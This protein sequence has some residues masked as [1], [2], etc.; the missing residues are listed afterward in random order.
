MLFFTP[1]GTSG[2]G[3][4]RDKEIDVSGLN[5]AALIAQLRELKSGRVHHFVTGGGSAKT[6]VTMDELHDDLSNFPF[7]NKQRV[8]VV[9]V[10]Q[11][12][13][14]A[15]EIYERGAKSEANRSF[16]DALKRIRKFDELRKAESK[17]KQQKAAEAAIKRLMRDQ[18]NKKPAAG[19]A[20]VIPG[21]GRRLMD[22][23][24]VVGSGGEDSEEEEE[25]GGE[26]GGGKEQN[27]VMDSLFRRLVESPFFSKSD[28]TVLYA[29][30]FLESQKGR[31]V[32]QASLRKLEEEEHER[33]IAHC[34]MSGDYSLR[35]GVLKGNLLGGEKV[36][37]L[38]QH[39]VVELNPTASEL[40]TNQNLSYEVM[41]TDFDTIAN[42]LL[43]LLKIDPELPIAQLRNAI[44]H[45][46]LL[47]Q[48]WST[49]FHANKKEGYLSAK[50]QTLK[51]N[52][53]L[54]KGSIRD[55]Y[56]SAYPGENWGFLDVP[57]DERE[58]KLS[59]KAK[60]NA[61]QAAM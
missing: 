37:E 19:K 55:F 61:R 9:F 49:V 26:E 1:I 17:E 3:K 10:S 5:K 24:S 8:R 52:G 54:K 39:F 28:A 45:Q 42:F 43:L 50:G 4:T 15:R 30:N 40:F 46:P 53:Q 2:S 6:E 35:A 18:G 32:Y 56:E 47:D 38:Q 27:P 34:L 23:A 20:K 41:I 29:M 59:E 13:P 36:H 22:G 33:V 25:G 14:E 44:T 60:E 57:K 58:R 51:R 7:E 16:P 12:P 31:K 48:L 11:L 21:N